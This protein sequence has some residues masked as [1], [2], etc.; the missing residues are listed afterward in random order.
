MSRRKERMALTAA[1]LLAGLYVSLPCLAA[2]DAD[3]ALPS[4]PE[5]WKE[6]LEA[7]WESMV[8]DGL[9]GD[10]DEVQD[11]DQDLFRILERALAAGSVVR[12][13]ELELSWDPGRGIFRYTLPDG[14][15]L[16]MNVPLG[17]WTREGVRITASSGISF[18]QVW[19]DGTLTAL[20]GRDAYTQEGS[21]EILALDAGSREKTGY[22]VTVAFHLYR[23]LT[24][25]LTHINVPAGLRLSR[26]T[27]EGVPLENP[28]GEERYLHLEQDG[29][30][31]LEF[32]DNQGNPCWNMEFVRD[33]QAPA[34]LF[35]RPVEGL[36]LT[37]PVGFRP[38][39][40]SARIRILRNG[41]ESYASSWRIAKQGNYQ[42]EVLDAAGNGREYEFTLRTGAD[43][44]DPRLLIIPCAALAAIAVC[45]F[46]WR[47][48]MR[49]I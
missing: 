35:D 3:P 22:Q 32:E 43:F 36:V 20:G 7:E 42:I 8:Q 49:V 19:L 26:V 30:Y 48:N 23:D 2:Q 10:S 31:L 24:R 37:E 33:T 25:A 38:T 12:D 46:K 34:L 28:T 41:E 21:Y 29:A 1:A 15:Y 6:E 16:E 40:A 9:E 27:L 45:Y 11:M 39:E 17:G 14:E 13:P 44:R 5:G 4:L 47:G 18:Y